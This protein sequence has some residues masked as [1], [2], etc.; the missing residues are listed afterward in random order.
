MTRGDYARGVCAR[1][2]IPWTTATQTLAAISASDWGIA[3][4]LA[5][6]IRAELARIPSYLAFLESKEIAS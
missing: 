5:L 4:Q 3:G 2:F 1:I 6:T